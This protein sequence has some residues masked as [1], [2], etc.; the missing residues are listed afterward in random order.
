MGDDSVEVVAYFGDASGSANGSLSGGD[1]SDISAV[2]TG[3]ST[4]SALGTLGG[5][6]AFPLA[7]PAII[8]D[9]NNDGLVDASDVTLLNSVLSGTPRAQIPA[10]PTNVPITAYGPDPL[11]EPAG[12]AAALRRAA[13]WWCR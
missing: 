10:I 13:R 1:A 8:A 12:H 9:L 6:S 4:N 2:A 3:I 11:L 7:D 5:F